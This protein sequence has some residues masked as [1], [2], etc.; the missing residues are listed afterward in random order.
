MVWLLNCF[1]GAGSRTQLLSYIK[2]DQNA[3]IFYTKSQFTFSG[4][5]TAGKY[6]AAAGAA[7]PGALRVMCDL[8]PIDGQGAGTKKCPALADGA[9]FCLGLGHL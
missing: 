9:F 2:L 4:L 6:G 7:A 5:S 1:A 3:S 8:F